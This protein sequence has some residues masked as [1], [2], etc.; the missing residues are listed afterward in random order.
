MAS[1]GA[2]RRAAEAGY[3]EVYVLSEGIVGWVNAG[4]PTEKMP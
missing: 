3:K 1:H 2:A 4:K